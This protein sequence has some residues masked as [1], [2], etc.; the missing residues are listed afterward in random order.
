MQ[1]NRIRTVILD[2]NLSVRA[3]APLFE[4]LFKCAGLP[5]EID[6]AAVKHLDAPC[7][8]LLLA[9]K[10]SSLASNTAFEIITPSKNF[11]ESLDALG[12]AAFLGP[13]SELGHVS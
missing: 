12:L 11:L 2:Q 9:A 5:L 7:A 8:Q 10:R 4:V 13:K 1:E 6:A 3:A